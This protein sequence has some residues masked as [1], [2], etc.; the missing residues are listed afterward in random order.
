MEAITD[1]GMDLSA[2]CG[3]ALACATRHVIIGSGD[4][5]R[6]GPPSEEEED[7]LDQAF[8]VTRTS[9][10]ACQIVLDGSLDGL[11]VRLPPKLS[12]N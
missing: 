10:L 6:V 1:A 7:M 9:R 11:C 12:G 5:S 4:F 2:I 3:G 8:H